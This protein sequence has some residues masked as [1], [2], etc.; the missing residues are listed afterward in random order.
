MI[1]G[2]SSFDVIT[3]CQYTLP[4][5]SGQLLFHVSLARYIEACRAVEI[6]ELVAVLGG[7]PRL[8]VEHLAGAL[9]DPSWARTAVALLGEG[10][11]TSSQLR[12]HVNVL[13]NEVRIWAIQVLEAHCPLTLGLVADRCCTV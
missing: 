7:V 11:P 1:W 8:C 3:L 6:R 10:D 12:M 5:H 13:C 2:C 4:K 9:T